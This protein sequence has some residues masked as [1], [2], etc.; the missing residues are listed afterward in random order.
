MK[1]F[2]LMPTDN[3]DQEVVAKCGSLYPFI[4]TKSK[5]IAYAKKVKAEFPNVHFELTEGGTWGNLEL[6]QAF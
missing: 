6:V 4:T 3:F 5:A 2:N 1:H